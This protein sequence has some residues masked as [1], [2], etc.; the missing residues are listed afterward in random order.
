MAPVARHRGKRR[1]ARSRGRCLLG[2]LDDVWGAL[3]AKGSE[4]P[5]ELALAIGGDGGS[6]RLRMTERPGGWTYRR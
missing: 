5:V 1:T 2:S 3:A 6:E 4:H